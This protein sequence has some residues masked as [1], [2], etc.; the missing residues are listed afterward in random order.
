MS[1]SL[2]LAK[3]L[4]E[5]HRLQ[6]EIARHRRLVDRDLRGLGDATRRLASWRTYVERF[7]GPVLL[8]SF[9]VGLIAGAGWRARSWRRQ[10]GRWLITA[11]WN[12]AKSIAWTDLLA[13][14]SALRSAPADGQP[15]DD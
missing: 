6:A 14:W 3:S 10:L 1:R 5:K 15:V 11:G 2:S 12:S 13:V 8:A 7:P 4:R 9:G